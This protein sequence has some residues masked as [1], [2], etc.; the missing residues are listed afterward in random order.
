M[1][2]LL[3]CIADDFTGATDLANMLVRDGMRTVQLIGVP[4]RRR[5]CRRCRRRGGGAQVAHHPG[6]RGGRQSLAA[7]AWLRAQGA[8]QIQ[9][10]Y[11]ST[12]DSTDRGNIGP[13][14]EALLDA[15][16]ADFTIAC[17]AFP[18]NGRTIFKGHLFVGDLLLVRHPHAPPSADADDRRQPGRGAAAPEQGAGRAGAV[19]GR[20]PRARRDPRALCRA[21][22]RRRP[23]GDRRCARATP[24]AGAR[25]RGRRS[26]ADHRRLGHRHGPAGELPPPGP[27]PAGRAGRRAAARSPGHAAV[28]A[29]SCSAATLGRSSA[30]A[31]RAGRRCA[32]D[33]MALAAGGDD[34]GARARLRRG[35]SRR[36]AGADQLVGA[37]RGGREGA[38]AARPRARRALVEAAMARDRAG[39]GRARRAPPGRGRRRD[40]GRGGRRRSAS[41]ARASARRSIPAC[42]GPS[43][44]GE[45]P[46]R[47]R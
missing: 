18:E 14:S 17:P 45:P 43:S 47:W 23:A 26:R 19:C 37:A 6:R 16:G 7:L 42:P 12:F 28:L 22:R 13:V 4:E 1:S 39:P 31:P 34:V 3:G 27:A 38:G 46:L 30:I 36:G 10:K 8:R 11:C 33:P 2:L 21:A 40:L 20:R 41:R 5:R 35:A 25:R 15:L 29:G 32:L 24:P 9:F 44:L